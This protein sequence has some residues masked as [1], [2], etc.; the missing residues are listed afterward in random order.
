MA[1]KPAAASAYKKA[2]QPAMNQFCAM[3]LCYLLTITQA[4]AS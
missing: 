2:S 1:A 4:R 3:N